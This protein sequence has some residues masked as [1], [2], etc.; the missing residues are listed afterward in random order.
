VS[1]SSSSGGVTHRV[2]R[3]QS[4]QSVLLHPPL[5]P[6]YCRPFPTA[7]VW[8]LT[9]DGWVAADVDEHLDARGGVGGLDHKPGARQQQQQRR[10]RGMLPGKPRRFGD[11][12]MRAAAD[13]GGATLLLL[14]CY[15]WCCCWCCWPGRCCSPWFGCDVLPFHLLHGAPLV[16]VVVVQELLQQQTKVYEKGHRCLAASVDAAA[17]TAGSWRCRG[18]RRCV[19]AHLQVLWDGPQAPAARLLVGIQKGLQL[20]HVRHGLAAGWPNLHGN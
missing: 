15:W 3:C 5:S 2:S 8:C 7:C 20:L 1:G 16:P 4:A 11:H 6:L 17:C 13:G 12:H 9:R 14:C 18:A 19:C 10:W